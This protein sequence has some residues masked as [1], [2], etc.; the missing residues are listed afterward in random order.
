LGRELDVSVNVRDRL[1]EEVSGRQD[2]A[3][4]DPVMW[5]VIANKYLA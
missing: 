3:G 5:L 4:R 2:V 1:P